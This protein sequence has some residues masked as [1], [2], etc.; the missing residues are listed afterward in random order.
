[1][2][3]SPSQRTFIHANALIVGETG[4]LLRGPSGAGKSALTLELLSLARQRGD[5]ASLIG[6]DRVSIEA[7]GGRL[8]ARPHPKIAGLIEARG[9]GIL[10][11]PYEAGGVIHAIVDLAPDADTHERLPD[12]ATQKTTLLDISL[13]RRCIPAWNPYAGATIIDFIQLLMQN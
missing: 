12:P 2:N 6:D 4:L 3:A 9:L 7:S 11:L 13:P 1:M 5:F 8:I 10:R